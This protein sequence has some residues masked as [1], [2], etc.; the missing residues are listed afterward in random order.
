MAFYFILTT[1]ILTANQSAF[2]YMNT[3]I[4]LLYPLLT[5]LSTG[6]FIVSYRYFVEERRARDI[7]KM[8]SSYVT[9]RVVNVLIEHPEMAKL[10]GSRREVTVLFADIRGF[11]PFS[12]RHE[13][14]EVVAILNEYLSIMTDIILRWEGTLD[15]FIGDAIV[16]YWGAPME[17]KNHAELA[18]RCALD[19][20]SR[21]QELQ[22]KW[23]SE[24]QTPLSIG[25]GL[26]SGEVLVGNIGAE[27]KKME[28]TV[29]GD[30]VNIGSRVEALTK[31]FNTDIMMT[32]MVL[33]KIT[34]PVES[35]IIGHVSIDGVGNVLV[36]GKKKQIRLYK[37]KSLDDSSISSITENMEEID[38]QMEEK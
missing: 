15:K 22:K 37:M 38:C 29:I 23:T 8:F 1:F 7:R 26:N 28:Y 21:M 18:I 5:V 20:N 33:K 31:K 10:G 11:T 19:M 12:E 4:N 9:E 35:N 3:R 6:T 17:Q 13:P 32:E 16:A 34:E 24:G 2:I 27:G 30:N 25:I 14:E 36:K